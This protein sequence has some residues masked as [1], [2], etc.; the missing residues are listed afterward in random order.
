MHSLNFG[1][2]TLSQRP[3]FGVRFGAD[4]PQSPFDDDDAAANR[5]TF[6]RVR[7]AMEE[8]D[9]FG[10]IELLDM[11]AKIKQKFNLPD[12]TPEQLRDWDI[13]DAIGWNDIERAAYGL[14]AGADPNAHT[15]RVM[16]VASNTAVWETP[17]PSR[18]LELFLAHPQ[19][20]PNPAVAMAVREGNP[21]A[22]E[23]LLDDPRVDKKT[24][25]FR[26]LLASFPFGKDR[27]RKTGLMFERDRLVLERLLEDDLDLDLNARSRRTLWTPLH[28]I[29]FA[30][31]EEALDLLLAKPGVDPN[32]R[33]QPK[34]KEGYKALEV[35]QREIDTRREQLEA[36]TKPKTIRRAE[37]EIALMERMA[38]KIYAY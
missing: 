24:P 22:L 36:M 13:E 35:L 21:W 10:T 32:I 31:N 5:D 23:T 11:M 3:Q 27:D 19:F 18:V 25:E 12:P 17:P 6:E 34:D 29:A 2:F 15:R 14:M 9:P 1:Q 8:A 16:Q 30:H 33:T 20:D 4:K 38:A 7:D 28:E 26:N 37:E